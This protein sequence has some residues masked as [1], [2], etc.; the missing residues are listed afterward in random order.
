MVATVTGDTSTPAVAEPAV[1]AVNPA[2]EHTGLVAAVVA[3]NQLLRKGVDGIL[4]AMPE[5]GAVHECADLA[6]V[7]RLIQR[8]KLNIVITSTAS[9]PWLAGHRAAL[10]AAETIVLILIDQSSIDDLSSYPPGA[11][12]FLWQPDLTVAS[13]REALRQCRNGSHP[14]PSDLVRALLGR[15]DAPYRRSRARPVNLTLREQ[16]TLTLLVRGLSNKQIAKRLSISSHGAKRLVASIMLKLDAPNRTLA[17]VM[18]VKAGIVE[19]E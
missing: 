1:P 14:M 3:G 7:G 18:A 17:A 8:E 16:E 6:E 19:A 13:L 9:A 15:T 12:G 11:G 5:I 4:R 2:A 10:D